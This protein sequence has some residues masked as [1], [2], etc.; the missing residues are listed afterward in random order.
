MKN[1]IKSAVVMGAVA[2]AKR[3]FEAM[4]E[5]DAERALG[6]AGL[7]RKP[8]SSSRFV[9]GAALTVLGAAAGAGAVWLLTGGGAKV[10][11]QLSRYR[12]ADEEQ[13]DKDEPKARKRDND[14]NVVHGVS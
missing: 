14:R 2:G 7:M 3:V 4:K 8:A 13:R 11:E 12:K 5:I 9:S 6:Y 1:I 10:K